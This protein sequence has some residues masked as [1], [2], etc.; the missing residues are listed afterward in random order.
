MLTRSNVL[1]ITL[2]IFGYIS[3]A[4]AEMPIVPAGNTLSEMPPVPEKSLNRFVADLLDSKLGQN[5]LPFYISRYEIIK[6][7]LAKNYE[8]KTFSLKRE[9]LLAAALYKIDPIHIYSAIVGE[10]VFNVDIKDNLQEYALKLKIWQTHWNNKHPFSEIVDC[11]EML[12]CK[13]IES[14]YLKWDCYGYQW[15]KVFKNK[16][17]CGKTHPNTGLIKS[18][19]DPTA[20][21]RTYGLGQM[22]P[23]KILSITDLVSQVSGFPK[24]SIFEI[25]A[26]YAATLNPATTVHYIAAAAANSIKIYKKEAGIDISQNAGLTATLYNIGNER[27]RAIMLAKQNKQNKLAG[28]PLQMPQV[29]YYGWLVNHVREDIRKFLL[30]E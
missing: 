5:P 13:S 4:S 17:A 28:Q 21:G 20:A 29:N 6:H 1:L 19:F 3:M 26:V 16:M 10:H 7:K 8:T 30:A 2:I 27:A 24:L 25:D 9:I 12:I 22:G 18:F 23:V 14:E 15:E 11:P